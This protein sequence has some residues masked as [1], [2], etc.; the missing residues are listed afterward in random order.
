MNAAEI[1]NR[2]RTR[3]LDD[4]VCEDDDANA[5]FS[6]EEIYDAIDEAYIGFA[7]DTEML[8]DSRTD[9]VTLLTVTADDPWVDLS[10]KVIDIKRAR[11]ITPSKRHISVFNYQDMDFGSVNFNDYFN[12]STASNWEDSEGTP[13]AI[14]K[15]MDEGALRLYPTPD[16]AG[17]MRITITRLPLISISEATSGNPLEFDSHWKN[18]LVFGALRELYIREDSDETGG[19]DTARARDFDLMYNRQV[20]KAKRFR[21]KK[22]LR[23]N[24][25]I[26]YGGL[27]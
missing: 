11:L 8:R 24:A 12:V 16:E 26:R 14:I 13:R 18:A 17:T 20:V 7:L 6:D 9:S 4:P 15:N 19:V 23:K 5:L 3:Y 21:K 27:I 10:D 2:I 1:L 22:E 25:T